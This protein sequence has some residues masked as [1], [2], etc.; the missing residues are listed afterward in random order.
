MLPT[1]IRH[2]KPPHS[3]PIP[4]LHLL[5]DINKVTDLEVPAEALLCE[6]TGTDRAEVDA[7]LIFPERNEA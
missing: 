1:Y 3:D 6:I 4:L 5:K 2:S 7:P